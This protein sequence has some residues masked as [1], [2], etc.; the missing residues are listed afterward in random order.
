MENSKVFFL[1]PRFGIGGISKSL[2]FVANTCAES[3]F[4]VFCVSMS[5]EEQTIL[6]HESIKKLYCP[7]MLHGNPLINALVKIRYVYKL[8][9]LIKTIAP[10]IIIS[11]G[12]D[13]VRIAH[14]SSKPYKIPIIGSER[15]N[16][17][18]Y[19]KAQSK[20]YINCLNKC[21][22]VVFQTEG[23]KEYYPQKIQD[24]SVIIPN[25]AVQRFGKVTAT[26][27]ERSDHIVVCSRLS[28]EKRII[29]I[30]KAYSMSAKLKK[31]FVLYIYGDGPEEESIKAFVINHKLEELVIM[32]GN[33]QNVFEIESNAALFVLYSEYEGMPNALIEAMGMGIP[34]IASDCPPGGVSFVADKGE[35]VR[36][37]GS[38]DIEGL[39][40]AMEEVCFDSTISEYYS[41]KGLEINDVLNPLIIKKE[42]L[43]IVNNALS[44]RGAK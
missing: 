32:K 41:R 26:C 2:S 3:G 16:P 27:N 36:L 40:K 30:I 34:C 18:V 10:D 9:T 22:K 25:P 12:T 8:R 1:F 7:Y 19:S 23:A 5:D 39:S 21:N 42:W 29:E 6:L 11:F 43:A 35:R 37:V 4:Q 24:K 33:V 28:R 44:K 38:D 14:V 31:N 20:K 15:G 17:Y 13:L